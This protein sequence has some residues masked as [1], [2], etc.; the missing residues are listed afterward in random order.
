MGIVHLSMSYLNR[1][2]NSPNINYLAVMMTGMGNDGRE[3]MERLK[4]KWT[5][6]I[7]CRIS[8]KHLS[9]TACQKQLSMQDLLTKLLEIPRHMPETI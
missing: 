6:N 3:G 7:N 1:Q 8:R 5:N 9:F 2:Q 4:E